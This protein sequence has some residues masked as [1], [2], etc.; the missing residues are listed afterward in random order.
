MREKCGNDTINP[1]VN[2][3]LSSLPP[4]RRS[5]TQHIRRAN[6]QTAIWKRALLPSPDIPNPFE[7]H[8]W[9]ISEGEL[10]PLWTDEEEELILPDDVIE[11]ILIENTDEDK[12]ATDEFEEALRRNDDFNDDSE[13]EPE[14]D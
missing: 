7:G 9:H 5:L 8:G 13:S 6:Y 2:V 4:C 1:N 12:E 3:D 10:Q 11:D 14:E